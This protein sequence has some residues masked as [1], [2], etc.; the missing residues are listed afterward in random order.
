MLRVQHPYGAALTPEC[1]TR[2]LPPPSSTSRSRFNHSVGANPHRLPLPPSLDCL[3]LSTVLLHRYQSDLCLVLNPATS[4]HFQHRPLCHP[5]ESSLLLCPECFPTAPI[6][7]LQM[8]CTGWTTSMSGALPSWLSASV[9]RSSTDKHL[10][11]DSLSS[12]SIL[13]TGSICNYFSLCPFVCLFGQGF[14]M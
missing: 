3:W 13:P 1:A 2:P 11:P 10:L 9:L 4:Y 7:V 5:L 8:P 12:I 14:T 6:T